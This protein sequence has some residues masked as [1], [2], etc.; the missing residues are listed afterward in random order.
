VGTLL[1]FAAAVIMLRLAGSLLRRGDIAWG[2]GLLAYAVASG[3][4]A[5]GS[6]HGWDGTSFR[7]Y[8]LAGALLTA[9]LLGVG[10]LL[11]VGRRWAAPLGLVYAGLAAG[12]ALA[13]PV[14]GAFGTAIPSAQ[15]HLAMLP[16]VVAI[17]GNSLGTVAVILVALLTFR[18]RWL[19]NAFLLA[20]IGVA[21]LG[22][23]LAGTGT[24]AASSFA[25]VAAALL[26][27]GVAPPR[28]RA[29]FKLDARL[30]PAR[31]P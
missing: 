2:S 5:W 17:A 22:S 10:S 21:A 14:H 18:T 12:I 30:R 11:L 7:V 28:L 24:G 4:L 16:R 26:Y 9:P 13:M 19:G 25:A 15:D 23:A 1:S 20:G 8:Y 31:R 6:A 3:A 27:C 29:S